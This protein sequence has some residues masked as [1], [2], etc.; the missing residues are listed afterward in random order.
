M[1][2]E[3]IEELMEEI[4]SLREELGKTGKAL[5]ELMRE[6]S[7]LR[8]EVRYMR[9]KVQDIENTLRWRNVEVRQRMEDVEKYMG[10]MESQVIRAILDLTQRDGRPPHYNDISRYVTNRNPR[11]S[12]E[13]VNRCVRRMKE[14]GLLFSP[15]R[16]RFYI[17][18]EK[19]E[20][21]REKGMAKFLDKEG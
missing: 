19:V 1:S 18:P 9:E 2:R 6:N 7:R 13:T 20:E 11:V 10:R 14:K 21:L 15:G 3:I 17:L 16:G 12:V 4:R 8:G 5:R